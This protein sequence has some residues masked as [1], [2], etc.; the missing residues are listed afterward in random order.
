M[1]THI[2][3]ENDM[4]NAKHRGEAKTTHETVSKAESDIK[5][6]SET[7]AEAEPELK[8]KAKQ[9]PKP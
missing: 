3:Q 2:G 6:T 4:G 8:P 7:E 1:Y 9:E 5:N